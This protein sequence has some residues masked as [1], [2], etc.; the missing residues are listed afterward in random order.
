MFND[1]RI[2]VIV[3]HYGSGKTEFS[4]NYV[5]KL[6]E[7]NNNVAIA[8]LDVVNVY[9]RSR[10]KAELM[11]EKGIRVLSSAFGHHANLD[12][13]AIASGILGLL[14]D[15]ECQVVLDIGGDSTG[16]RVLARYKQII[17]HKGYDM[18]LVVNAFREETQSEEGVIRHINDIEK[19]T[20]LKVTGLINN[21]HLLR[22]TS[23]EDVKKGQTLIKSVSEKLDIPIK[24]VCAIDPIA[25]DIPSDFEGEV[26]PI[27][28]YMREEWM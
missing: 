1:K 24:Y 7:T 23:L 20:G 14:Q 3:G 4:V 10:E 16:A 12:L 26:L 8:D 9:F 17:Q 19:Q 28:M 18:F 27:Q 13:P 11:E 15:D 2:K 6:S 21:S 25:K 22:E 5:M